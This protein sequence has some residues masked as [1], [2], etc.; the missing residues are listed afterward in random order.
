MLNFPTGKKNCMSGECREGRGFSPPEQGGCIA[1]GSG[2]G[3]GHTPS[4]PCAEETLMSLLGQVVCS[5]WL[6][7]RAARA[8]GLLK[9][10]GRPCQQRGW[11]VTMGSRGTDAT[12]ADMQRWGSLLGSQLGP[13]LQPHSSTAEPVASVSPRLLC[14]R[15]QTEGQPPAMLHTEPHHCDHR[16][17]CG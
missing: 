8:V 11:Q 1:S 5:P 17:H 3:S 15:S 2:L 9:T 10:F 12:Q 7:C 6:S 13:L 14:L 4:L 16:L